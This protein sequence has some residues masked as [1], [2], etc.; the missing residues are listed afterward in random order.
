MALKS[1]PERMLTAW[2]LLIPVAYAPLFLIGERPG[3][4]AFEI[5]AAAFALALLPGLLRVRT[6][7]LDR[8]AA[9]LEPFAA[10]LLLLAIGAHFV[11]SVV[12]AQQQLAAFADFNQLGLFSQSTWS[13]LR[14]HPYANTHETLDGS[15]GSHFGIH[16]SPTLLL[17]APLYAVWP[18][19]LL[20][21]AFQ[22]LALSL[23][24]LPVYH[25][26]RPR[27]GAGAAMVL[28]LAVLAVPSFALGGPADFRDAN[29]LP[30]LLLAAV[31]AIESR[32]P[33]LVMVFALA[34]LG[35][36][37]DTGPT[38]VA[39]GLYALVRGRGVRIAAGVALLGAAWF[40][41]VT[42]FVMPAFWSEGLWMNPRAFFS[43]VLGNW[44][45][46]PLAAAR[47]MLTHPLA[48]LRA[49][50]TGESL[51][52]L[53]GLLTPLL[54]LPPFGDWALLVAL[55]SLALNLLSRLP[56]M[57][58]VSQGYS[59]VPLAFLALATVSLAARV[60]HSAL[61]VRRH[62]TALALG[63][64]VLAGTIPALGFGL[65]RPDAPVPPVAEARRVLELIPEREAV[66]APVSLYPA[67]CN[68]ED[69]GCWWSTGVK[70]REPEFRSR[71]AWIVLWPASDPPGEP[72][73]SALADSLAGDHR[74]VAHEGFAPFVVY[75]RN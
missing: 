65:G 25:L 37:E 11:W 55:P 9:A 61:P 18:S 46:T 6:R 29:L 36:R 43:N 54:L 4:R 3:R 57:R 69:F 48:V 74:F 50:T 30:V 56:F 34:A 22:S 20:L 1:L 17:I 60:A 2:V 24:P 35:V 64:I 23:I 31:W 66:Y 53:Y 67:L 5:A 14:G 19:P 32:R 10:R 62:G 16:F 58:A 41:V 40:V 72:R 63:L 71:Y 33:W 44:G 52:Y 70:G 47:A 39:L 49:A 42:R 28:A 13:L 59:L 21:L 38:L 45:P 26:L 12:R 75:Q 8:L 15:L 68:R 7:L 27:V 51:R 73:E